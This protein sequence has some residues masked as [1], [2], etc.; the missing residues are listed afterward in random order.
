[1]PVI[2]DGIDDC[3]QTSGNISTPWTSGF[4]VIVAV[5]INSFSNFDP[6]F[7]HTAGGPPGTSF[8]FDT[9][10]TKKL[11]LVVYDSSGSLVLLSTSDNALSTGSWLQLGASYTNDGYIKLYINGSVI[12]EGDTAGV[13]VQ[14]VSSPIGVGCFPNLT[15]FAD[16]TISFCSIWD[17]VL[18][19]EEVANVFNSKSKGKNTKPRQSDMSAYYVFDAGPNGSSADGVIIKDQIGNGYDVVGDNGSNNTGLTCIAENQYYYPSYPINISKGIS[20]L[21]IQ[22][23]TLKNMRRGLREPL[24]LGLM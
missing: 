9:I 21:P 23:Y 24:Q 11:R 19:D 16:I 6:F 4:T 10:D 5:N 1:M 22:Y 7:S 20:V 17:V 18:A 12:T 2:L 13:G 3:F 8:H 15:R 14:N